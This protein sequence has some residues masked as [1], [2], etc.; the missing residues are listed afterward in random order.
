MPLGPRTPLPPPPSDPAEPGP[1]GGP[2]G[3]SDEQIEAA[4]R[5]KERRLEDRTLQRALSI[6]RTNGN[7]SAAGRE[8]Y[9]PPPAALPAWDFL[10]KEARWMCVD[11]MQERRFKVSLSYQCA[12]AAAAFVAGSGALRPVK[13]RER[14]E[15]RLGD[16]RKQLGLAG[17]VKG[18]AEP[19]AW[20]PGVARGCADADGVE[21]PPTPPRVDITDRTPFTYDFESDLVDVLLREIES[22][23]KRRNAEFEDAL[24]EYDIELEQARRI[25]GAHKAKVSARGAGRGSGLGPCPPAREAGV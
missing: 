17:R 5:V 1:R 16:R 13:D 7:M 4:K 14:G 15:A 21:P 23:E 20:P 22:A 3:P 12:H 11:F 8:P 19:P 9:K 10:L 18:K 2:A 25:V 6:R 24:R